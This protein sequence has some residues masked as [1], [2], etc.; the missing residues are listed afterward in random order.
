MSESLIQSYV[1]N[2]Y[3]VSTI[4]RESSICMIPA[5]WYYETIVWTW[6]RETRKRGAML[7]QYDSGS[8][9]KYAIRHHAQICEGLAVDDRDE[10]RKKEEK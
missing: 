7:D 10:L 6:D 9:P 8:S 1:Q 2:R 3:F 4:Y 5:P